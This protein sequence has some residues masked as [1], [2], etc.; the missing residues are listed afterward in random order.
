M[1]DVTLAD[2][3]ICLRGSVLTEIRHTRQAAPASRAAEP[4]RRSR[5][6]ARRNDAPSSPHRRAR[7]GRWRLTSGAAALAVAAAFAGVIATW[8]IMSGT[9]PTE[10]DPIAAVLAAADAEVAFTDAQGGGTVTVI[11]SAE[12]DQAVVVVAGLPDT[13]SDRA[14]QVWT[15]EGTTPASA[16]VMNP[17]DSS[18]TVLVE[19]M[20]GIEV[21]A[22]TEEP[23]GGSQTPTLPMVADIALDA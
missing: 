6:T 4:D 7:H 13:G 14:Y 10:P 18:A 17:G 9:A 3:P 15:V 5:R 12:L 20:N 2:P 11:A 1:A 8:S 21:I 16:G 19:D 22:V 23:A